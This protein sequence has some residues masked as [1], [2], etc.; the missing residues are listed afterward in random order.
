MTPAHVLG[1]WDAKLKR[2]ASARQEQKQEEKTD[3][4]V[5]AMPDVVTQ[6]VRG[7]AAVRKRT[8]QL[9]LF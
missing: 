2:D 6:Q 7:V 4:T 8:G 3:H 1:F 9:T 5:R